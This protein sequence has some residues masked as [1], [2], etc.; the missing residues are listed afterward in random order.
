MDCYRLLLLSLDFLQYY[1]AI[2][3]E[4][5]ILSIYKHKLPSIFQNHACL[6]EEWKKAHFNQCTLSHFKDYGNT[7]LDPTVFNTHT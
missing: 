5:S 2:P 6:G 7:P 3:S 1:K 4:I